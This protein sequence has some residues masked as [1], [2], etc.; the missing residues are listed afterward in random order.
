MTDNIIKRLRADLSNL[1]L[2]PHDDPERR[3]KAEQ[4]NRSLDLVADLMSVMGAQRVD[5]PTAQQAVEVL[6]A[7]L[8]I[9]VP[10]ADRPDAFGALQRNV[11]NILPL[12]API[13]E[14][15]QAFKR[16]KQSGDD[17]PV[18]DGDSPEG[19]AMLRELGLDLDQLVSEVEA[20]LSR[21]N[22]DRKK[23]N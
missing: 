6:L 9:Q 3:A 2:Y 7:T 11:T 21:T 1:D 20:A 4:W 12:F 15:F 16:L 5:A 23:D 18:I 10:E 13:W 19:R 17:I 8:V 22:D 14:E